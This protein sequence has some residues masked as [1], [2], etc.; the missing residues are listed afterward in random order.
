MNKA[1]T[2][3]YQREASSALESGEEHPYSHINQQKPTPQ[4]SPDDVLN[5]I[6]F[7]PFQVIAFL[8]SGLTYFAYGCDISIFV[9]I[10][11]SVRGKWNVTDTEYSILPAC[12]SIPNVLGALFFSYISDRFG[13]WWPYALCIG[14]MGLFSI[15]SA[16]SNSFIA[17]IVLR[18]CASF[19]IGGIPGIAFPTVIE[20]L[21]VRNR[22][23][24][25]VMNMFMAV[26]GLCLS[27]GLAWWLIPMYP[28]FG[29]RYYINVVAVPTLIVTAFRLMFYVESPRYL[30]ANGKFRRAWRVFKIIAKI[31][32]KELTDLVSRDEFN[33]ISAINRNGGKKQRSI[34][35]QVLQI[36]H[37]KYLRSTLPMSVILV[38]ESV[39]YL[40][41]QLFLPN[42]LERVGVGTYFTIMMSSAAQLPGVVLMSIIIEWPGVGRL[43]AL[44]FF[45]FLAMLFFL[46]LTL[47]QT[48]LSIPLFLIFIYFAAGP[49]AGLNYTYIS[50]VYPTSI[51]SIT[52]SYFYILQALTYLVGSLVSSQV[53]DVS[54]HWVFP[55]FFTITFF[56]QLCFSFVLNYEPKGRKLK[57]LMK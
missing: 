53:A 45:S 21:P 49:I 9:F 43:N 36:F 7:G 6:G 27:C 48:S 37:P 41:S 14:W 34:F 29:W 17:L 25:A 44:R 42:F 54:Q 40:S 22:G 8:L 32:R 47:I 39:G 10:G 28:V 57:D 31:N 52:T 55:A 1:G 4:L 24:V 12:T 38:T 35:V 50:E 51:R 46:L 56:V 16:Y 18:C 33:S 19:G 26:L 23:S 30:I 3:T 5:R 15:G 11:D 20:F 13:R 2:V